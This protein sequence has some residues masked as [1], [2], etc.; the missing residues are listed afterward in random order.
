MADVFDADAGAE[1]SY[2]AIVPDLLRATQLPLPGT[3]TVAIPRPTR[4]AAWWIAATVSRAANQKYRVA[5]K[6]TV[7][8]CG[9]LPKL[10]RRPPVVAVARTPKLQKSELA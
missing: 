1:W 7:L 10:E 4:D 3:A 5:L 6:R 8:A 2:K 9:R